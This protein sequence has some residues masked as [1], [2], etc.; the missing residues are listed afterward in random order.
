MIKGKKNYQYYNNLAFDNET[1]LEFY[2]ICEEAVKNGTIK[3]FEFQE[4]YLLQDE[5]IDWRGDKISKIQHI[6]D[7]KITLNDN[8]V[9]IVDTKGGGAF[10]HDEVS[11]IKRKIWMYKNQGI[12]YYMISKTPK[13]LGGVWVETS[14]GHDFLTKLRNKYKKLFPNEN[15][16]SRDCRKMEVK[17]WHIYFEYENMLGLF[18]IMKKEYTK[19]DLIKIAKEKKANESK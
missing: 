10:T 4:T 13:Y 11:A 9:M 17:H 5:F 1:E 12:P 19:Q 15:T 2:K 6:P 7:F 16:R 8:T 14:K 18:Y 3:T